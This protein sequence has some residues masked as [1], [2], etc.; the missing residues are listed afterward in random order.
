VQSLAR[1]A[2]LLTSNGVPFQHGT[3]AGGG[4]P[5]LWVAARDAGH[6]VLQFV[7]S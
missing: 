6:A 5:C 1:L 3:C 4:Q 7:A 2:H